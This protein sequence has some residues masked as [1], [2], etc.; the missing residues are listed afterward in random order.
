MDQ[1]LNIGSLMTSDPVCV[2]ADLSV[3][4]ARKIMRSYQVRQLPVLRFGKVAGVFTE[5][6]LRMA[7]SILKGSSLS[8]EHL[9]D[10]APYVVSPEANV[11]EVLHEMHRLKLDYAVVARA[12][13]QPIGIFTRQDI[14][15]LLLNK[16]RHQG[17]LAAS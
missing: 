6:N 3:D 7:K 13:D 10:L 17:K 8:V 16:T 11:G 14:L 12:D 9:M 5:S 15:S 4:E 1:Y 2:D